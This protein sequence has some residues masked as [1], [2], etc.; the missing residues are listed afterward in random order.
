M[1]D[2][3]QALSFVSLLHTLTRSQLSLTLAC[4]CVCLCF[5]GDNGRFLDTVAAKTLTLFFFFFSG[6]FLCVCVCVFFGGGR[7]YER[8]ISNFY[9]LQPPLSFMSP[10]LFQW[11][12]SD[13]KVT[14]ASEDKNVFFPNNTVLVG[15]GRLQLCATIT[16]VYLIL[17]VMLWRIVNGDKLLCF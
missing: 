9:Q 4:V 11:T 12:R 7:F 1:W 15:P 6:F 3:V 14:V 13:S 16:R 2:Q 5:M 17:N 8:S 10:C